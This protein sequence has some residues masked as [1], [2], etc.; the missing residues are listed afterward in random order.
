MIGNQDTELKYAYT[1]E[2]TNTRFINE[3]SYSTEMLCPRYLIGTPGCI[4]AGLDCDSVSYVKRL[5]IPASIID[6]IQE[7][8][9][10]GRS[11]NI[12]NI[13]QNTYTIAL[14]LH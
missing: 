8:G 4:G 14:R 12:K 13:C 9:R 11:N 6:F 1:T 2:F 3:T 7:M 10:C 5:G